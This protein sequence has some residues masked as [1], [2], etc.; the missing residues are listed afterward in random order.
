MQKI[1]KHP[2]LDIP[3]V[4]KG[5]FKFKGKVIECDKNFTIAAALHQAGHPIHS[6]SLKNRERSLEC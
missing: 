2:I 3:V 5:S 6:H 1:D 4:N